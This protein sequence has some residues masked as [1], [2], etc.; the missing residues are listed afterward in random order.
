MAA[1]LGHLPIRVAAED[2]TVR[3]IF[4]DSS[5]VPLLLGRADFLDRFILMI[6]ARRQ[7]LVLTPSATA[8]G[9]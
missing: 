6:D 3:C 1:R 5:R 4:V 7:K 8:T 2:L 9:A